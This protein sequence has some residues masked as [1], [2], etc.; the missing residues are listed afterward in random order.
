MEYRG[1]GCSGKCCVREI[2]A[3]SAVD[4]NYPRDSSFF[5]Y[6]SRGREKSVLANLRK[7]RSFID[8]RYANEF[9]G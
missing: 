4:C 3:H 1:A 2:G 9:F 7:R 8:A 6:Q 5:Q